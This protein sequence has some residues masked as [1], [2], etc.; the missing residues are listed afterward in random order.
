M[1]NITPMDAWLRFWLCTVLVVLCAT[2]SQA[3]DKKIRTERGGWARVDLVGQ[4]YGKGAQGDTLNV[5]EK[6]VM[7]VD[8]PT[9]R[10]RYVTSILNTDGAKITLDKIT[11]GCWVYVRGGE[12]PDHRIGAKEIV[13]LP[14]KMTVEEARRY[15]SNRNL[16]TWV[17]NRQR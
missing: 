14:G 10:G 2:A 9:K 12:F 8:V 6:T 7:L 4:V 5:Q 17:D 16:P 3:A 13:L 15:G 1:T 11:K